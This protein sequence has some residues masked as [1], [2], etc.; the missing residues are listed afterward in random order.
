MIEDLATRDLGA[1]SSSV[2]PKFVKKLAT[3]IR[4]SV[5]QCIVDS[6]S[7]ELLACRLMREGVQG[8]REVHTKKPEDGYS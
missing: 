6:A 7:Y 5:T 3:Q 1:P 2:K 8:E 4:D